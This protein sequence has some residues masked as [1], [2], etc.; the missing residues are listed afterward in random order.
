L[1][2]F[3]L[4]SARPFAKKKIVLKI[5]H[6]Y[7][8]LCHWKFNNSKNEIQFIKEKYWVF[9]QTYILCKSAQQYVFIPKSPPSHQ[10]LPPPPLPPNPLSIYSADTSAQVSLLH[11]RFV[12]LFK[13][14]KNRL[15]EVVKF[16]S[17]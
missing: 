17:C 6:K 14:W 1:I 10:H 15:P 9:T 7:T 8:I 11:S 16:A 4:F 13:N 12:G 2:K 3:S 5:S